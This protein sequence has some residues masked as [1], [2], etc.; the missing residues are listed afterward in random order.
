MSDALNQL[1]Q[2]AEMAKSRL[3][4]LNGATVETVYDGETL[5]EIREKMAITE[6]DQETRDFI[7]KIAESHLDLILS[8][9]NVNEI[10]GK[11]PEV[12]VPIKFHKSGYVRE[13]SLID[14]MSTFFIG[15]SISDKGDQGDLIHEIKTAAM[16]IG[17]EA[18]NFEFMNRDF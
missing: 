10:F 8:S 4:G 12:L 18:K 1:S 11:Q 17:I 16:E 5:R 7:I 3:S 14:A 9:E 6:I 15:I 13:I 2:V